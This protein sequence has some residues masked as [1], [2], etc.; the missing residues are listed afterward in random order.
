[1]ALAPARTPSP[2]R[3]LGR[4]AMIFIV[5]DDP[6]VRRSLT[7]LLRSAGYEARAFATAAECLAHVDGTGAAVGCVILDVHMPGMGGPDLQEVINRREPPVPVIILTATDDADLRAMAVAAGVAE[8][9]RKPCDSIVLLRAIA[10]A[11][12]QTPPPSPTLAGTQPQTKAHAG[13]S[14]S[15]STG[16]DD[17]GNFVLEE[18]RGLYR[19]A[20]S[21]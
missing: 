14:G 4:P 8:V 6:S 19:P 20:G 16:V 2:S 9:L 1:M 15:S 11:T 10:E 17:P 13:D 12:G 18:G 5:D 21:V 3:D 7:R